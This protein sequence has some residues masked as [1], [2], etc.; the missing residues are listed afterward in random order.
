MGATGALGG[1]CLKQCLEAKHDVTVLAR[2]PAKIPSELRDRITVVEG[3]G[4]DPEAVTRA[5][6]GGCEVVLLAVGIDAR[7]PEDI[8]TNVTRHVVDAMPRLGVRRLVWCGGG[9]TIVEDDAV[10]LG[11]RFVAFFASTFMA[12][13]SRDKQHQFDL[14]IASRHV[15]WVGVRPL[16]MREGERR[17][18]Y[19]I[20]FHPYN[21]MSKIHFADCAHAMLRMLDDDTWRHKAPIVQ[22]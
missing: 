10:T 20:G 21:G 9:S 1:E 8:C 7:S 19:R 22:Y 12:K 17:G 3:D 13:R 16:Q 2:T 4:L 15:D 18:V 6:E 14:L 5:L 11:S